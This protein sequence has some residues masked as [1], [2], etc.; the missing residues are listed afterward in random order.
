MDNEKVPCDDIEV[1]IIKTK[2]DSKNR[3]R[4]SFA[5]ELMKDEAELRYIKDKDDEDFKQKVDDMIDEIG[6]LDVINTQ[7]DDIE[8]GMLHLLS[9]DNIEF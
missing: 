1:E 8:G 4:T 3:T 9:D 7:L 5:Q 6:K 2:K